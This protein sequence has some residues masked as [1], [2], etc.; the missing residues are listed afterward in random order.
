MESLPG[1]DD[2]RLK[3]PYEDEDWEEECP[4]DKNGN[5]WC[6]GY[7]FP[8]RLGC[9]GCLW[10]MDEVLGAIVSKGVTDE[11]EA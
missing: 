1:H 6:E 2:W 11:S 10:E 3:S 9:K 5:C 4:L 8:H 7:T